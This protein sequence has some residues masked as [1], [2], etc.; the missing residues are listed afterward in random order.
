MAENL[1]SYA[2]S[3]LH[4]D[5]Q[6]G[7]NTYRFYDARINADVERRLELEMRLAYADFIIYVR[8]YL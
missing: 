4:K 8:K 1:V 6:A 2:D 5:K 3:A 7:R